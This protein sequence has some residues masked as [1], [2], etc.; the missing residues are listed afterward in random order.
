MTIESNPTDRSKMTQKG[1]LT[2]KQ[3]GIP[4]SAVISSVKTHDIKL[5]T[6]VV[7]NVII[8]R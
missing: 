7:D 4:L 1:D 8:R 5:V 3:Q 6:D 2:D